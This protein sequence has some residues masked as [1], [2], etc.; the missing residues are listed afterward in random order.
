M[1]IT[2]KAARVN[3]GLNQKQ[4]AKL[5]GISEDALSNY[6]RAKS[7]PD[8]PTIKK[9]EDVYGVEYKDLIFLTGNTI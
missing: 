5:L 9:M 7:F 8:V 1:A 2:L 3:K 6:E 4:A